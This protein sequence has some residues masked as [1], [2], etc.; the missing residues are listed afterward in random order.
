MDAFFVR[1]VVGIS[2]SYGLFM[3][4]SDRVDDLHAAVS[5]SF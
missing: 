3:I 5:S 2:I 1:F 4:I